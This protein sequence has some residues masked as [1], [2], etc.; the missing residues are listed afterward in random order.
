MSDSKEWAGIIPEF[1][2]DI[3]SRIPAGMVLIAILAFSVLSGYQIDKIGKWLLEG[4]VGE[5][6]LAFVF[7][8]YFGASYAITIPLTIFGPIARSSYSWIVWKSIK[9]LYNTEIYELEQY[10]GYCA[11]TKK[12][13]RML[14]DKLKVLDV[15]ARV[16]LPKLEAEVCLCDQ[17]AV[18][19]A[20]G[21]IV[22]YANS[23]ISIK[24]FFIFIC[25]VIGFLIGG[26]YRFHHLIARHISFSRIAKTMDEAQPENPAD[27]KSQVA[28]KFESLSGQTNE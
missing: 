6:P 1:Y 19:F 7:I 5:F 13:Y 21:A 10:Y 3:I 2:Y 24:M 28:D 16:L 4:G 8:L 25:I 27:L 14:H 17:M 11:E 18:S 20:L 23:V 26:G 15:N 12:F 9:A 22:L